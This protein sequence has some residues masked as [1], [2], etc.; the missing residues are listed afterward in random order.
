MTKAKQTFEKLALLGNHNLGEISKLTGIPKKDVRTYYHGLRAPNTMLISTD[1]VSKDI[2]DIWTKREKY[3]KFRKAT[4]YLDTKPD[5]K[6]SKVI[7]KKHSKTMDQL[8]G[9]VVNTQYG[10]MRKY[11]SLK[12]PKISR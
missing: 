7:F 8:L 9:E 10:L 6:E 5:S 3:N 11:H 2:K 12:N 4:G 1:E